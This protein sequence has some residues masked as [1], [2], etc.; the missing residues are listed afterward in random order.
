[1]V[2]GFWL[3]YG[4]SGCSRDYFPT[5]PPSLD[6]LPLMLRMLPPFFCADEEDSK[7]NRIMVMKVMKTVMMNDDS[8]DE[9]DDE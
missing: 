5:W 2:S 8:E 3:W 7:S 4:G 6:A 9:Y 1:M